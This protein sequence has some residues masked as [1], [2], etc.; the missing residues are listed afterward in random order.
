MML[1]QCL[2]YPVG[3]LIAQ[4]RAHRFEGAIEGIALASDRSFRGAADIAEI[5]RKSVRIT[6][7]IAEH[8]KRDCHANY[9]DLE[10]T[11]QSIDFG[12]ERLR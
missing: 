4:G 3:D 10:I 11:D 6:F 8:F 9:V 12:R 5:E 1:D 7:S 2:A